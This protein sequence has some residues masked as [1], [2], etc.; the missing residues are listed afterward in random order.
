MDP[1]EQASDSPLGRIALVFQANNRECARQL[2][3]A[4]ADLE[5]LQ[6][7]LDEAM[8]RMSSAFRRVSH[9]L[10]DGEVHTLVVNLQYQDICGQLVASLRQRLA[11]TEA[12]VGGLNIPFAAAMAAGRNLADP[13]LSGQTAQ[14][15][16]GLA[17]AARGQPA[18]P[19]AQEHPGCGPVELF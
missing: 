4:D 18:C 3:A 17:E 2:S 14:W 1:I 8:N 9:A 10:D 16:A 7:L 19:V 15:D 12:L 11:G 6:G 13:P 5:R